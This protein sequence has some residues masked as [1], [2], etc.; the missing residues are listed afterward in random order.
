MV[1]GGGALGSEWTLGSNE[2][3]SSNL[4]L[5]D[6]VHTRVTASE[7]PS[8]TPEISPQGQS[9]LGVIMCLMALQSPG[10]IWSRK[11]KPSALAF[12]K[13]RWEAV[14]YAQSVIPSYPRMRILHN[15]RQK[16]TK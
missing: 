3:Y 14:P 1:G 10:L 2:L 13:L 16:T 7:T 6:H 5:P 4:S 9:L 11:L 12:G 15:R 8:P